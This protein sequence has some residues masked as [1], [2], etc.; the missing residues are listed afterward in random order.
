[1][2]S[3]GV[4]RNDKAYADPEIIDACGIATLG[5]AGKV[6]VRKVPDGTPISADESKNMHEAFFKKN[7]CIVGVAILLSF[8]NLALK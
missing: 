6:A 8:L 5:L 4:A 3:F 1:M 2:I 7:C